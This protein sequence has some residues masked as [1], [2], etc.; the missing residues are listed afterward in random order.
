MDESLNPKTKGAAF[1]PDRPVVGE[2]PSL[3]MAKEAVTNDL[4]VSKPTNTVE[5]TPGM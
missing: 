2:S 4:T 5:E 1:L 3:T